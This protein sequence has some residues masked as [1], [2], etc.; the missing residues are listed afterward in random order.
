[1]RAAGDT[2]EI[3]H[4]ASA[5][6]LGT[7]CRRE[8]PDIVVIDEDTPEGASGALVRALGKAVSALDGAPEVLLLRRDFDAPRS[9]APGV[10]RIVELPKPLN[11]HVLASV[12]A[13]MA[14]RVAERRGAAR[15]Q[16]SKQ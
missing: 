12:L 13:K 8:C 6:E 1:V 10:V 5:A 3:E 16:S 11:A 15:A 9:D 4:V 7:V 2:V 14:T